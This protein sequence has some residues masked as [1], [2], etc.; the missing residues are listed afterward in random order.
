MKSF[1]TCFAGNRLGAVSA[2]LLVLLLPVS[3]AEA[4]RKK[5][6]EDLT[7]VFLS[8]EYSQ[9]L[10]GA[11]SRIASQEEIDAYQ[12]LATDEEAVRF[13]DEFW[14]RHDGGRPWPE[15]GNRQLFEERQAEADKLFS[16]AAYAG[17]RTDRGTVF[18]LYGP[19]DEIFYEISPRPPKR[20]VEVWYYGTK[21]ETALDGGEPK[22]TY[23]FTRPKDLTEFYV[24]PP[25]RRTRPVGG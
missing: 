13:I 12:R 16:E 19:P 25:I 6:A 14:E 1:S 2:L 23:Y 3:A 18:V 15:K 22:A 20:S 10:V 21:A 4:K 5:K 11:V 17:R 9:W 7:N 8:I 24:G